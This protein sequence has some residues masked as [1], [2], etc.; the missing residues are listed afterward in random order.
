MTDSVASVQVWA[1]G[2]RVSERHEEF[3]LVIPNDKER[4]SEKE[5]SLLGV[6]WGELLQPIYKASDSLLANE[7]A[8]LLPADNTCTM[9]FAAH[10]EDRARRRSALVVAAT[11]SID[12]ANVRSAA[13]TLGQLRRLVMRLGTAYA[14]A[15]AQAQPYLQEQLKSGKFL[16]ERNFSLERESADDTINWETIAREIHRWRGVRGMSSALLLK[17]GANILFGTRDELE[18]GRAKSG[19]VDGILD[20]AVGEIAPTTD[21]ISVWHRQSE[22][23]VRVDDT[24]KDSQ[25]D[26]A[27]PS[28]EQKIDR[29]LEN[30]NRIID[31]LDTMGEIVRLILGGRPK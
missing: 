10:R 28:V 22:P 12:W 5:K 17:L 23:R 9:A 1:K 29:V 21:K 2:F 7:F 27:S 18:R 3:Q 13:K 19:D 15:F 14:S 8:V 20:V 24:T 16:A 26:V 31:M 6:E 4:L 25:K 11:A 30:Q